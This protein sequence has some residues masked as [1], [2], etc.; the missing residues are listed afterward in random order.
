MLGRLD[1]ILA[2]GITSSVIL[3]KLYNI[4]EPQFPKMRNK[5]NNIFYKDFFEKLNYTLYI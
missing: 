4:S 5:D 1:R 3:G 2:P